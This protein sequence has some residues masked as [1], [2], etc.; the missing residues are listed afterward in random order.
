[1]QVTLTAGPSIGK[2]ALADASLAGH[3]KQPPTASDRVVQSRQQLG[4]L[5]LSPHEHTF[6]ASLRSALRP[7]VHAAHSR[8][9]R[10]TATG[11]AVDFWRP[12]PDQAACMGRLREP[13]TRLAP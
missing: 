2:A 5:V 8:G 11:I 4:E 13:Q 9:F 6:A 10:N 1:V 3:E 12:R 7:P